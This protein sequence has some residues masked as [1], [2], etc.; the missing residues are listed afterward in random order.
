V[1]PW[2]TVA[3]VPVAGGDLWF[4]ACAP[5][6]AFEPHLTAGLSARWPDRVAE[7]LAEDGDRSWLLMRDAGTPLVRLAND[8]ALWLRALPRYAEL[9]L[10]GRGA[11]NAPI[12]S[13]AIWRTC[14]DGTDDFGGA[15]RGSCL[16]RLD[17]VAR[18]LE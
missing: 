9:Q 18:R 14:G 8:P 12:A 13:A 1:R 6:Q 15:S 5:V 10:H 4:K 16:S 2:A 3:R 17:S 7:V 11:P